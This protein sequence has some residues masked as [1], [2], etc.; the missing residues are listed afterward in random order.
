MRMC[1]LV[2]T[3]EARKSMTFVVTRVTKKTIIRKLTNRFFINT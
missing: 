1:T 3:G 2:F